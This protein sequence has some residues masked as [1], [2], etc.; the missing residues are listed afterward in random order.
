[1]VLASHYNIGENRE[2]LSGLNPSPP[3]RDLGDQF[4][5]CTFLICNLRMILH[6][7]TRERPGA[8]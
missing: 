7:Q 3:L 6:S 2:N 8:L 1:M 4:V 5:A